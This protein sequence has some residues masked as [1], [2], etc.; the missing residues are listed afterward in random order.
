MLHGLRSGDQSRV[1]YGFVVHFSRRRV[2]FIDD[3]IKR[4]TVSVA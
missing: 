4:R 3:A 2:G 1:E